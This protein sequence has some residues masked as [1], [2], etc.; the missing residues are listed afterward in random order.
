VGQ[1]AR[2][3]CRVDRLRRAF[4][5]RA[6]PGRPT[7]RRLEARGHPRVRLGCM[8]FHPVRLEL[9]HERCAASALP[10][11]GLLA[12]DL[13]VRPRCVLSARRL[14]E[15]RAAPR[16]APLGL[17]SG[18]SRAPSREARLS[19]RFPARNRGRLLGAAPRA[20]PAPR[21]AR[22]LRPDDQVPDRAALA[23]LDLGLEA[24]RCGLPGPASRPA[25]AA[26]AAGDRRDR[27]LLLAK[28]EDGAA[29]GGPDGSPAARVRARADPLVLPLSALVLP[30]RRVRRL[31]GRARDGSRRGPGTA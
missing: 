20:E 22:L 19:G 6:R 3:P 16:R 11:L 12:R 21:R 10:H 4:A 29:T 8:A 13:L 18:R 28:T 9:E 15:V 14:D 24:V 23:V 25:S 5:D 1:P 30:V 31:D 27:R 17:L 2:R 26:G 7:V